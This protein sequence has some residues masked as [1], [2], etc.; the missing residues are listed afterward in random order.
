MRDNSTPPPLPVQGI[1]VRRLPIGPDEAFVF[2]RVDGRASVEEIS[3]STGLPLERV[4]RCLLTLARYG[5]VLDG[6]GS[7]DEDEDDPQSAPGKSVSG[8]APSA[9]GPIGQ[10]SP[11]PPAPARSVRPFYDP[12][13]LEEPA[14]LAPE[15]K[16]QILDFYYRMPTLNHYELLG[17]DFGADRLTLK[18]AYYSAVAL[19]HPD[20]YFG[21]SLGTFR[22]RMEKCFARLTEAHEVLSSAERRQEYDVYLSTRRQATLLR[23]A[24]TED[25]TPEELEEIER[26]LAG[27]T[28]PTVTTRQE[29]ES[30]PPQSLVTARDPQTPPPPHSRIAAAS[31]ESTPPRSLSE[32]ERRRTLARKLGA[33]PASLRPPAPSPRPSAPAITPVPKEYLADHLRRHYDQHVRDSMRQRAAAQLDLAEEALRRSDPVAASTSLQNVRSLVP[34]DAE[35]GTRLEDLHARAE[36]ALGD[37]LFRQADYEEKSG[38][39]AD[40]ARTYERAARATP[41]AELWESAGRC[42]LESSGDLRQAGDCVRRALSLAPDRPSSHVLLGRIFLAAGMRS[43]A[44][45]ELQRA[46]SLAPDDVTI[47]SLLQRVQRGQD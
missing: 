30:A 33:G 4:K 12:A 3:F 26:E 8:T 5:A 41:R 42:L 2:S 20:R 35:L 39:A 19:Y 24:L 31:E 40:A 1:D 17:V 43:S 46:R 37:T 23:R 7:Q 38:R 13:E 10:P 28:Y 44:I 16:R 25:V 34:L 9:A 21:K 29:V 15:R 18:A 32:E 11:T 45:S 36:T 27:A 22:E 6:L 14:E 47:T